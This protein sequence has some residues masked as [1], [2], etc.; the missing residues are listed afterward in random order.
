MVSEK[1][2]N[3][4]NRCIYDGEKMMNRHVRRLGL[5]MCVSLVINFAVAANARVVS[6]FDEL[7]TVDRIIGSIIN[8]AIMIVN[9][10]IGE[11]SFL[12]RIWIYLGASFV[13]YTILFW[14]LFSLWDRIRSGRK[15]EHTQKSS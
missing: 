9:C 15:Y 12:D 13:L 11:G 6:S 1:R 3:W 5:S 7:S 8:P 2:L 10:I 4:K 14:V